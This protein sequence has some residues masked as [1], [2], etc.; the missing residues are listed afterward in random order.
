MRIPHHLPA[1]ST[2]VDCKSDKDG[3]ADEDT[4]AGTKASTVDV[5]AEV[6]INKANKMEHFILW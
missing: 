3:F 4:Y 5:V 1:V 2:A 6:A